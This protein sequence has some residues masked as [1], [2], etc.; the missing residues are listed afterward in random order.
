MLGERVKGLETRM[1]AME[2]KLLGNGQPGLIWRLETYL[3]VQED[4][5]KQEIKRD[6]SI[7][8]WIAV[9]GVTAAFAKILVEKMLHL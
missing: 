7:K 9:A 6:K 1:D 8:R 4:R 3:A 5:D 2:H